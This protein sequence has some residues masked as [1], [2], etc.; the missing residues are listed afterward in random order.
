[1]TDPNLADRSA[2]ETVEDAVAADA[3]DLSGTLQVTTNTGTD[4]SGYDWSEITAVYQFQTVINYP[5]IPTQVNISRTVRMR[6]VPD[7]STAP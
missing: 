6:N 2:Y 4:P 1:M 3:S 5:G 7:Y